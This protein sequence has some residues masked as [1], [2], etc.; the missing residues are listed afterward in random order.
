MDRSVIIIAHA[1]D[2]LGFYI[3]DYSPTVEELIKILDG[4]HCAVALERNVCISF[5]HLNN[6][7]N[8]LRLRVFQLWLV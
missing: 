4:D 8:H 7:P 6:S 2:G 1:I 5:G 3:F